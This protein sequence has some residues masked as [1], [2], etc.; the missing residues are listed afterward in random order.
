M[1]VPRPSLEGRHVTTKVQKPVGPGSRPGSGG[2]AQQPPPSPGAALP[3]LRRSRHNSDHRPQL[4]RAPSVP[5]EAAGALHAGSPRLWLSS[6]HTLHL[7]CQPPRP[8]GA[9][10]LHARPP[11]HFLPGQARL[12]AMFLS[13]PLSPL[14]EKS[15]PN[16]L[17]RKQTPDICFQMQISGSRPFLPLNLTPEQGQ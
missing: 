4:W 12:Q 11:V 8:P 5:G 17:L 13:P 16:T 7:G 15:E 9:W 1:C 3:S 14:P 2:E 10:H 6:A